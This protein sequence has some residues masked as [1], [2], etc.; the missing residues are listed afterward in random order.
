MAT[1]PNAPPVSRTR[2]A[3][4]AAVTGGTVAAAAVGCT[5]AVAGGTPTVAT[6]DP[7][8]AISSCEDAPNAPVDGDRDAA[9]HAPRYLLVLTG[10][11]TAEAEATQALT[12]ILDA[13]TVGATVT[14]LTPT[15]STAP[16]PLAGQGTNP[17]AR[18]LLRCAALRDAAASLTAAADGNTAPG[19]VFALLKTGFDQ[20]AGAARP[21][22]TARRATPDT[23]IVIGPS[24]TSTTVAVTGEAL[25]NPLVLLHRIATAG[26]K[27]D[28]AGWRFAFTTPDATDASP[29][30]VAARELWR[31]YAHDCGGALV[32][33]TP[34]YTSIGTVP[35]S[36]A[37]PPTPLPPV[38]PARVNHG[39]KITINAKALFATDSAKLTPH[40]TAA[41]DRVLSH[42]A[43]ATTIRVVGYT[44][45]TTV[46]GH[47]DYNDRLSRARATA[48]ANYLT[49]HLRA[50]VPVTVIG[51]G[52]RHP[53]APNTPAT[54][55]LNRRVEITIYTQ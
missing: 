9:A 25:D 29:T 13:A 40:S 24:T 14:I 47:P 45:A 55:Y 15:R 2:R 6:G 31:S 50:H 7:R 33:W 26:L 48:C 49:K 38:T 46:S 17:S 12:V 11:K 1:I 36:P 35:L 27:R 34:T 21:A 18:H 53:I 39:I 30:G 23:V 37:A 8:A 10:G 19:D 51:D 41:L 43:H 22:A 28:C 16:I 32:T 52:A 3:L 20:L 5:G 42:T 54:R 44:D 4:A